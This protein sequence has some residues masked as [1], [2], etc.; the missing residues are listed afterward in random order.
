MSWRSRRRSVWERR[1]PQ[2]TK[3]DRKN[4]YYPDLPKNYQISQY[5]LPFSR[6]G[7]LEIPVTEGWRW[8]RKCHLTRI[9]LEEDTGKLTHSDGG[10]SEVDLNRAGIPLLEI[11]TEPEIRT[12]A[13]ARGC[14][15]ELRLT[16]RYLEV[17]DCEMQEGSLRCDANVNLHIAKDGQKVATP[18]VEIKN[19][20]S[21]R[22]VEKALI[23]EIE[24]QYQK[25]QA[26][27]LTI[28]DAPKT[29]RGWDDF[30]E[31]TKPQREKES[32]AD[33]RYFPE[34]DLVP[35]EVDYGLDQPHS[36]FNRRATHGP[37]SAVRVAIRPVE[38]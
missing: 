37:P 31:V 1:S 35:V 13:D 6:G 34:P 16:L 28:K 33:Y 30:D 29:T 22:S 32:L 14:L 21:F 9:H 25:W 12:P 5:D 15:E 8:W 17:S 2:F 24:R 11:V 3:W 7:H 36:H 10:F 4:Y 19:L 38:V 18:I 23:Y 20:N 27:G 26:D